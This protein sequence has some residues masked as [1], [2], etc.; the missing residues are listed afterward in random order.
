LVLSGA[1]IMVMDL[2]SCDFAPY[3]SEGQRLF[4]SHGAELTN[5][6]RSIWNAV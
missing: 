1:L 6:E 3:N 2:D 4:R 5:G